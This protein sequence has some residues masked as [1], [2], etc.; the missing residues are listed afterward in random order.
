MN[1]LYLIKWHTF[2]Y[3]EFGVCACFESKQKA[4]SFLNL[5]DVVG[6]K[7]MIF[8]LTLVPFYD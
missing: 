2:D 4:E 1:E 8:T 6:N 5:L 7:N 3:S